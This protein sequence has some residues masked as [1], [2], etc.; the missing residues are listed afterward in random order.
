[1]HLNAQNI[2]SAENRIKHLKMQF[3]F[4]LH[5]T[6][7]EQNWFPKDSKLT[8]VNVIGIV[9]LCPGVQRQTGLHAENQAWRSTLEAASFGPMNFYNPSEWGD[10]KY[11]LEG[12]GFPEKLSRFKFKCTRISHE[13]SS[14]LGELKNKVLKTFRSKKVW[15]WSVTLFFSLFKLFKIILP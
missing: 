14:R 15:T 9:R 1:M 8:I 11:E 3:D 4:W 5:P 2:Q 7:P 10:W 12:V 6:C 13:V